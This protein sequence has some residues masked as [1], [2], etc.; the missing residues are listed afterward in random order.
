[1]TLGVFFHGCYAVITSSS[2]HLLQELSKRTTFI[3]VSQQLN[4]VRNR[5]C[6]DKKLSAEEVD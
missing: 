5:C 2:L 3:R 4:Q 1:M 6:S